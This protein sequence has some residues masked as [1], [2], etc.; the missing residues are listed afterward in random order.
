MTLH[1]PNH[2]HSPLNC[3]S[4]ATTKRGTNLWP[5]TIRNVYGSLIQ[6]LAEDKPQAVWLLSLKPVTPKKPLIR[7]KQNEYKEINI[8]RIVAFLH[9]PVTNKM[10][11]DPGIRRNY[12][13]QVRFYLHR[14]TELQKKHSD[15]ISA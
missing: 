1:N 8:N 5:Q 10:D 12:Q 11:C 15:I 9:I 6:G 3:T 13:Q 7:S 14:E 2:N 4:Y